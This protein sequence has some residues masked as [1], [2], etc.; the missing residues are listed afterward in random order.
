MNKHIN[1]NKYRA[2]TNYTENEYKQF[3]ANKNF[4]GLASFMYAKPTMGKVLYTV[5]D[6][7][8]TKWSKVEDISSA[9]SLKTKYL[10][11]AENIDGVIVNM[12][13]TYIGGNNLSLLETKGDFG[14]RLKNVAAASRY[15]FIR[16]G[17]L[18]DILINKNDT[19][20]LP[21][22]SFEGHEIEY[23]FFLFSIPML[24]I[25]GSEGM[26]LGHA[27]KIL[28]RN[29]NDIRKTLYDYLKKDKPIKTS[30][31]WFRGFEGD[32][33]Q[34]DNEAQWIISGNVE[35]VNTTTTRITEIPINTSVSSFIKKLDVMVDAKIIVD[36]SDLCDPKNDKVLFEIKHTREFGVRTEEEMLVVFKLHSK[37]TE[38]Y[39][40]IDENNSVLRCKSADEI[41]NHY[42]K[43]KLHYLQLRKDSMLSLIKQDILQLK[44]KIEFINDIVTNKIIINKKSKENIIAQFNN[45]GIIMIDNSFDYL[46]RMPIYSLTQEKIQELKNQMEA[47]K[48]E[49]KKVKDMSVNEMWL[50][51][52]DKLPKSL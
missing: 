37:I 5:Y 15:I 28:G 10:G 44:S 4:Q 3:G 34:G 7:N 19:P 50:E 21:Q 8:V 18:F 45:P 16:K 26:G 25:N 35:K 12:S 33:N 51:D 22:Y 27:Q 31:P 36:Y 11:G 1:K 43:I 41:F 29:P 24:L 9:T 38:N 48:L 39:T 42:I 23:Q 40:C 49:Y 52:L 20:I 2:I 30:K 46:L 14:G 13:K 17:A 47:K 32:I 6:D